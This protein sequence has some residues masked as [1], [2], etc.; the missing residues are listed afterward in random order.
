MLNALL[1]GLIASASGF[2]A[3]PS[4]A[5]RRA[6]IAAVMGLE[7]VAAACLEDECSVD[8]VAALVSELKS[9]A[10]ALSKRNA[11]V[12]VLL[13]QLEALNKNPE[14]NRGEIE[15][16]VQ[17]ASRSFSTIEAFSFPGEPLGYTGEVG[18][19]TT[20]GKALA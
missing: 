7:D 9:E 18:T 20:A 4:L 15:K 2:I 16:I 3:A 8:T 10:A 1:I 5:S 14:A 17:S 19:T 12:L 11:Q 6:P 13:G